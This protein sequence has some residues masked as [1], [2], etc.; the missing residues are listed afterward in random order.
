M[1]KKEGEILRELN[2]P[3]ITKNGYLDW[4]KFPIDSVLKQAIS[5]TE[6]DFQSACRILTSMNSAGRFE[7]GIFLF[8][9][10]HN[11]DDIARKESI[12]EALGYIKTKETTDLLFRELRRTVSSNSTRKYIDRILKSLKRFPLEFIEDG[13]EGL[14]KDDRWSYR[15]KKKFREILEGVRYPDW[16]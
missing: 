16:G 4:T 6:Q 10:I 12:V 13:F 1:P 14:L 11:S 7:A 9:L 8:G 15:M 3:W 5:L 2:M